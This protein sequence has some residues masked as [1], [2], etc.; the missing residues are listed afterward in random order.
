MKAAIVTDEQGL[1]IVELPDP[2][3]GPGDL[4]LRVTA[5]GICGSDFKAVH[6]LPRGTVMGHEFCG[7]VVAVGRDLTGEWKEGRH[8]TALPV[9]G[10]GRC[11]ACVLGDVARCATADLIGVG[12]S[13][14]AF[15]QFVRVS[16]RE[17][18]A[19]PDLPTD[20]TAALVEPLAVGL[21]AVNAARLEPGAR[22]AVVGAG[23]VGLAAVSWA[24]LLGAGEIVVSD[25][26]SARRE[27][28]GR[29]GA[30]DAIDPTSHPLSGS[31]DAVF[32][33]VGIPG[34]LDVCAGAAA[35]HGTVVVA[36]VCME[37]DP[38]LPLMALLK[39]LTV[40]FAVYYR[41]H[42]FAHALGALARGLIDPA[43]FVTD[44]V[45]LDGIG[46][47]FASLPTSPGQRKVLVRP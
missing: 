47:A 23:P 44:R 11:R 45:A 2:A 21:H 33:C 4:V 30:T 37:P 40:R 10:C 5:C 35:T 46:D 22:V 26:A 15:A 32:E 39:E 34:M 7:E 28:A 1:D 43:P 24:R 3:P 8:A 13:A 29:F 20:D 38:F 31:F 41:R 36:G 17:A 18:F 25:P 6:S 12:G 27:A 42:E 9:F 16:G 14:G 19:V